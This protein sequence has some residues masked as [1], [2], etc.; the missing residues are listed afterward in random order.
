VTGVEGRRKGIQSR[1]TKGVYNKITI[2]L[3][4]KEI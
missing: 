3:G 4:E 1:T 2:W